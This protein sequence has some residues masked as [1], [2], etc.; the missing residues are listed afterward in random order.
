M[1]TPRRPPGRYDERRSLPRPARF[2]LVGLLGLTLLALLVVAFQRFQARTTTYAVLGY[3]VLDDQRVEVRFR[4]DVPVGG[5]V[6]CG[7]RARALDG[8]VVGE[9]RVQVGPQRSSPVVVTRLLTTRSR[10][11]TGEVTGC[12]P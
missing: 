8:A 7:V 3:K 5:T 6:H 11:V 1:T 10:A 9:E 12:S 4:V 2:A